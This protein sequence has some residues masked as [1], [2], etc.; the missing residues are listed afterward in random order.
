MAS[1]PGKW[2]AFKTLYPKAPIEAGTFEQMQIVLNAPAFPTD[3]HNKMRVRDLNNSQVKDL[4]VQ[5]RKALDEVNARVSVLETQKAALT[6]LFINRM[7]EDDVTRYPFTD[8]VSLGA[9]FE[10]I[11]NVKDKTKLKEW[12]K[13]TGQEDILTVNYQTLA[14]IV[15]QMLLEGQPIPEFIEVFM[16]SKLTASGLKTTKGETTE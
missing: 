12:V 5:V 7:E 15:K 2:A 8:G 13:E 14:S 9:S 10:P 1:K 3:P 11:P 4:Y 6:Y 16:K